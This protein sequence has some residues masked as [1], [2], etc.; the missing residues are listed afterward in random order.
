[1]RKLNQIYVKLLAWL[2]NYLYYKISKISTKLNNNIRVKHRII[3]YKQ[4]F[5]TNIEKDSKVLDI[6]CGNGFLTCKIAEKAQKVVAIDI[7][8]EAIS[9]AKN[10]FAGGNIE[11]VIGDA[12][13]YNFKERFNYIVLSN[14]LE[15]IY[16]RIEFLKKIKDLAEKFLIRVPLINRSWLSIY[17]KELGIEYRLSKSHYIEYTLQSFK[18]EIESAGFKICS[19]SIQFGEIWAIVEKIE[20]I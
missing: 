5:L 18:N 3:N 10:I 14:I 13:K 6:G 1:M 16:N 20:G 17:K 19:Y 15:H 11:Y 12:T 7:S 2:H 4:F 8:R 9:I